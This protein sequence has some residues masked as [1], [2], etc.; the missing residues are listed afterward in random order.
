LT[1]AARVQTAIELLDLIVDAAR[2][3]GAA[4]DTIATR[5][6]KDR[7]YAGSGDRRAIRDL[8]WRAIRR[9]GKLP[10][11][12]RSAIVALADDDGDLAALFTGDPRAPDPIM[13][14]EPRASGSVMPKWLL[15]HLDARIGGRGGNA[16]ELAALLDRAPLD[17]RINPARADGVDMP[18]G[19]A[20][21]QPLLGLRL[22]GDTPVQDSGAYLY[23]AIEV[24][25]AGSQW[26][27]WACQAQPGQAVIDLCAGAGG[28][29]LALA[30][31][32]GGEGRL[33]ACDSD[34]R[35]IQSLPPRAE[36]AGAEG[37][38]TRLLNP[39]DEMAMLDDLVGKADIVLVDAPCS[40]SGTWRRNPEARWRLT[41][42]RL[43]RLIVQQ[44]K[45][46][47][48]AAQL[49]APGGALVYAVCALTQGEGEGQVGAF[50]SRH[51]GW[52]AEDPIGGLGTDSVGRRAGSGRL[53]TPLHD[54]TD[55]FF[56]AKLRAR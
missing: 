5:F 17:L 24:Q 4:A 36:R 32:M 55:G 56:M 8:A 53:L 44:A 27:S 29:T 28:K 6:F 37:I 25:D 40:G 54:A 34:R 47:D 42:A 33:I 23:G 19:T 45:L 30:A 22:P 1:P 21:P 12:G 18:E 10:Q 7:R 20:L 46:L 51:S 43:E 26:V 48:L 31:Q 35:R 2:E 50:L 39:G 52:T 41:P 38:E 3:G 13:A 49:V 16:A 9:F 14:D 11:D 15:P